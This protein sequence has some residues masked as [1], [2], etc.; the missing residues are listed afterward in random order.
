VGVAGATWNVQLMPLKFLGPDGTGYTS[1]AVDAVNYATAMG[2]RIISNSWGGIDFSQSLEDAINAANGV[3]VLFVVA[4]GND[5]VDTDETPTYPACYPCPNIISVAATDDNDQLASFSN[6]GTA[7]VELAA[8]GVGIES[9][10]PVTATA[11]M[12]SEGLPTSYG[13]LSGTSMATPLVSGAAALA[14]AQNPSLTVAQ[15]K[16]QIIQRVDSKAQL[17]GIVQSAGRLDLYNVV[18]TSWHAVQRPG[19][20]Q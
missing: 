7:T 10:L 1:D 9:T 19:G 18:N 20:Q 14:L 4:A 5:G 12:T 8:P 16:N 3:G 17:A 6:Y 2:A 15:L 13:Q 11:A